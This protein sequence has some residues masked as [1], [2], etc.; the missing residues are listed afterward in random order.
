MVG[1]ERWHELILEL[2]LFCNWDVVLVNETWREIGED[3]YTLQSG[4][5]W[6]GSGGTKGKHGVGFVLHRRLQRSIRWFVALSE[7]LFFLGLGIGR[8]QISCIVA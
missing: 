5:E 2:D 4:Y 3:M 7:R 6:F 8:V 1:D